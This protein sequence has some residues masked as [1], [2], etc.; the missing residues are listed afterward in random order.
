M[1]HKH[2]LDRYALDQAAVMQIV[3][4]QVVCCLDANAIHESQASY[5][6]SWYICMEVCKFM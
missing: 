1:A 5:G 4:Y 2:I 6:H 3:L